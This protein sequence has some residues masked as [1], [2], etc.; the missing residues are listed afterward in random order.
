MNIAFICNEYPPAGHGGLGNVVERLALGLTARGHKIRVIGFYPEAA[1][2]ICN[3]VHVERLRIPDGPLVWL[4]ARHQLFCKLS[5]WCENSEI[6][7]VEAPLSQGLIAAF[8]PL[9]VPLLIRCHGSQVIKRRAAGQ[10]VPLP[11]RIFEYLAL[12]RADACCAVS[13]FMADEVSSVYKKKREIHVLYNPLPEYALQAKLQEFRLRRDVVYAGTLSEAKG[14]IHLINAWKRVNAEEPAAVL[15]LAGNVG[16]FLAGADMRK[17]FNEQKAKLQRLNIRLYGMLSCN[18]LI[19]LFCQTR[20]AI[21]PSLMEAFG[22]AAA[23]ARACGCASII[24]R[25]GSGPELVDHKVDG[26]LVNPSDVIEIKDA[27]LELLRN[28]ELA[29]TVA[30]RGRQRVLELCHPQ[31]VLDQSEAFYEAC[32]AQF[33]A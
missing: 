23:E 17:W 3:G 18:D 29:E 12:R 2:E 20:V 21:F 6:D 15:H 28:D 16:E 10:K 24:S 22:L 4:K 9:P 26:L 1:E 25:S 13:S 8:P 33:S 7:L 19:E 11:H 5:K 30:T 31:T 27:L 32:L 14:I